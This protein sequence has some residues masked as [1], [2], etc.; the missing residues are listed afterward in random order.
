MTGN[1]D[2]IEYST[3]SGKG[4]DDIRNN[5]LFLDWRRD[6]PNNHTISEGIPTNGNIYL[7]II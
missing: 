6:E 2:W 5:A 1:F 7:F 4:F 3:T